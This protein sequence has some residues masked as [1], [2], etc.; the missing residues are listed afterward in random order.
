VVWLL[1]FEAD[2]SRFDPAKAGVLEVEFFLSHLWGPSLLEVERHR[3][4]HP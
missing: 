3:R 1:E 4:R 2:G